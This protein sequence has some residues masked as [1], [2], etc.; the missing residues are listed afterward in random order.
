M[1]S[2]NSQLFPQNKLLKTQ[3]A[4]HR[5]SSLISFLTYKYLYHFTTLD[6]AAMPD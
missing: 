6:S 3:Q 5:L 4:Q 2:E 1:L